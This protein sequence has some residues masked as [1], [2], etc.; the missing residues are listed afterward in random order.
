MYKYTLIKKITYIGPQ[1]TLHLH[2]H[3]TVVIQSCN[4]TYVLFGASSHGLT[5]IIVPHITLMCRKLF[6]SRVQMKPKH[7]APNSAGCQAK[8]RKYTDVFG[9]ECA[10]FS[11]TFCESSGNSVCEGGKAHPTVVSLTSSN[12]PAL[13]VCV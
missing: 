10:S 13:R 5:T 11:P 8:I 9:V 2:A 6:L 4:N 7:K 12:P 3:D 1:Y